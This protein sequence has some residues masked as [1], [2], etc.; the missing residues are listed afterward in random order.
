MIV[1]SAKKYNCFE[2]LGYDFLLDE[3]LRV[4]LL[5]VLIKILI[6]KKNR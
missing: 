2:L 4:W 5:E 6:I 3:D 1:N